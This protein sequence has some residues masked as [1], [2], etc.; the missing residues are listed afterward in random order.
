MLMV[1]SRLYPV[2]VEAAAV[3]RT[4]A[5]VVFVVEESTGGGT[6]G[7]EVAHRLHAA[8]AGPA[9]T[10]GDAH[11]RARQRHPHRRPPRTRGAA[12]GL[13]H[14]PADLGGAA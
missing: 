7:A 10:A 5:E 3:E 12:A 4:G 6:W 11:P 2:A 8:A 14:P 9:A 13:D 1:P